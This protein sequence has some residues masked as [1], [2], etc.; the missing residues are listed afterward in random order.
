MIILILGLTIGT[1]WV[2][3]KPA[4]STFKVAIITDTTR[5]D[6]AFHDMIFKGVDEAKEKYG[7]GV[8]ELP[9]KP[10]P[11]TESIIGTIDHPEIKLII[12]AGSAVS[13][14]FF[15]LAQRFPEKKFVGFDTYIQSISKK[16]LGHILPNVLDIRFEEEKGSA[17]VGA[18]AAGLAIAYNKPHIGILLAKDIPS[19]WKFEIGYKWGAKWMLEEWLPHN[20]PE[21]LFNYSKDF[22]F[23]EYADTFSDIQKGYEIAKS[24]Y[25]KGAVAVYSVAGPLWQGVNKALKEQVPT[26]GEM[27]P[28]FWIGVDSDQDWINPGF[29]IASMMKRADRATMFVI[30]LVKD[31]KFQQ[32][33]EEN[34]GTLLLGMESLVSGESV[35]GISISTLNDLN[36]FIK[37]G[38]SEEKY[39]GKKLLPTTPSEIKAKVEKMRNSQP[40]WIWRAIKE[41]EEKIRSNKPIADLDKNGE[42]EYIPV[43]DNSSKVKYWRDVLG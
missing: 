26:D 1:M 18:L 21:L 31:G 14:S 11:K 29:V 12:G 23:C 7:I 8:I 19:L 35:D 43:A 5:G 40:E 10:Y 30:K 36:E 4:K 20:K 16:K 22:V 41:L 34:N 2:F 13:D 9:V 28:P 6:L 17:L 38:I 33:V 37:M 27:G 42:L 15:E 25:E 3:I 39:V 24:Q 32:I